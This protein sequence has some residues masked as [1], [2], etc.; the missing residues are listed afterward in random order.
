VGAF[1]MDKKPMPL[2]GTAGSSKEAPVVT[3]R[4]VYVAEEGDLVSYQGPLKQPD[5]H[6]VGENASD[7]ADYPIIQGCIRWFLDQI[8]LI[9]S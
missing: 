5:T 4:R 1:H 9:L 7:K 6:A 3:R 8:S 2:L